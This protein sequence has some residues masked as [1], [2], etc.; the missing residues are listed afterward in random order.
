MRRETV[1]HFAETAE[2]FRVTPP[3]AAGYLLVLIGTH[4]GKATRR[5]EGGR[6]LDGM[7]DVFGELPDHIVPDHGQDGEHGRSGGDGV[8]DTGVEH[9]GGAETGVVPG[10]GNAGKGKGKGPPAK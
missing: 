4:S 7:V 8:G 10:L 9:A 6:K 1:P 2:P 3:E 5:V